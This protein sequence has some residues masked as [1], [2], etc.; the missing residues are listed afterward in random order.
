MR[1]QW[2]VLLA[3]TTVEDLLK[4]NDVPEFLRSLSVT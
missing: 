2:R 1:A 3:E 4:K